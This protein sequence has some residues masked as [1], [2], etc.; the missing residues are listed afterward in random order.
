VLFTA[1]LCII[2]RK[3]YTAVKIII[4]TKL[5]IT[6]QSKKQVFAYEKFSYCCKAKE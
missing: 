2:S 5:K 3:E 4:K 6:F 1:F